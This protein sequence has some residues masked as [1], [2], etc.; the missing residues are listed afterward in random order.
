[1][2]HPEIRGQDIVGL[3]LNVIPTHKDMVNIKY[4]TNN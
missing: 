4:L 3:L 2:T 1:M